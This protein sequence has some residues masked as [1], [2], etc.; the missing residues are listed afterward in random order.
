VLIEVLFAV[1]LPAGV[2][3]LIY[4]AP[5]VVHPELQP[6]GADTPGYIWRS[7]VVRALGLGALQPDRFPA[8][9]QPLGNRPA[10]PVI[11]GILQSISGIDP[12]TFAWVSP[13]IFA[14]MAG[15]AASV[16]AVDGLG[17][18]RVR[19]PIYAIGLGG[20]AYL[21]W[22]A[23]GYA[24]NLAFD[25]IALAIA[26]VVVLHQRG[27]ASPLFGGVLLGAG[28]LTHWMFATAFAGVLLEYAGI[29]VWVRWHAVRSAARPTAEKE[30]KETRIPSGAVLR[31]L[32]TL[33]ASAFVLGAVGFLVFAPERP[34]SLPPVNEADRLAA[35]AAKLVARDPGLLLVITVPLAIV[36]FVFGLRGARRWPTILLAL[37][38]FL[39]IE[40]LVAW[41]GLHLPFPP[42]RWSAFALGLPILAVAAGPWAAAAFAA[43]AGPRA[44]EAGIALAVLVS[45]A[46]VGGGIAV[47]WNKDPQMTPEDR[48]QMALASRY[49]APLSEETPVI[50]VVSPRVRNLPIDRVLSGLPAERLPYVQVVAAR[51]NLAS[52]DLGLGIP[53]P[54]GAVVLVPQAFSGRESVRGG[55]ELGPG[56]RLLAGPPPPAPIAM[57]P[58]P[59]APGVV[60][61]AWYVAL[62]LAVATLAGWGWSLIIDVPVVGRLALSPVIGTAMLGLV[63]VVLARFGV[64]PD[65][66]GAVLDLALTSVSGFVVGVLVSGRSRGRRARVTSG[67]PRLAPVTHDNDA[68]A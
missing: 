33:L 58:P 57:P 11:A 51:V 7:G 42:Y 52:T 49:L 59:R 5:F 4:L 35:V 55:T 64:R 44:P 22:T 10:Y 15:L 30:A 16:L 24:P 2:I 66:P 32:W 54:L 17:E 34:D 14:T 23:V 19:A 12:A 6:L 8:P 27:R 60:R 53:V 68:M 25:G 67:G 65:G 26:L 31:G 28:L 9:I 39:A 56:L 38:A 41:Y 63:G 3:A 29:I 46:L 61:L 21:A 48:V 36:A 1:V 37:W 20:S 43:R 13:A 50:V 18:P 47:W 45:A 62:S 40:G